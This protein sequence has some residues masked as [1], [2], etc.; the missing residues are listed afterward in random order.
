[1]V[2][3]L[4]TV[5]LFGIIISILHLT[6]LVLLTKTEDVTVNGNQKYLIIA[7]SLTELASIVL[8]VI[9]ESIVN[10]TG[11]RRDSIGLYVRLY[12]MIVIPIMY[13]FIMFAIT[14]DSYFE[15]RLNIKY[16]LY[17][18]KNRTKKT[19]ILVCSIVN[20]TSLTFLCI[21]LSY[22]QPTLVLNIYEKIHNNLYIYLTPVTDTIFVIVAM[23]VYSYI[24]YKLY[25]SRR[26]EEALIK[27]LK[28][29]ETTT[30]I[31]L[32]VNRY[33]RYRVPFWI[34]LTFIL[35]WIVPNILQLI[36][37]SH[38]VF[39]EYFHLASYVLYRIGYIADAVIYILNLNNV[40]VKLGEIKRNIF[41]KITQ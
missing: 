35:F 12:S 28:C 4:I 23:T 2:L 29:N 14:L 38:P 9:R 6:G 36:S 21:I 5:L 30:N 25:K 22:Q 34:I 26:R 17:L 41:N 15:L 7:L 19:L 18:N 11:N 37:Y 16:H 13:Y 24:F 27:Q 33:R 20:I 1:M 39:H 40:K 10:T 32:T 31:I 3:N 8:S